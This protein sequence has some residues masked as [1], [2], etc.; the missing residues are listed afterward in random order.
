MD[1][2]MNTDIDMVMDTDTAH[3]HKTVTR[4]TCYS[5]L[6][7]RWEACTVLVLQPGIEPVSPAVEAWSQPLDRQG[8][9]C[10]SLLYPILQSL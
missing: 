8:S 7:L 4:N 1:K 6:F 2:D 5:L 10:Y 3:N 9:P